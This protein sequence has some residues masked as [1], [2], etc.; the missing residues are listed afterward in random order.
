MYFYENKK[1]TTGI[2]C[3]SGSGEGIVYSHS[4]YS[5][6]PFQIAT[7][8]TMLCLF[9]TAILSDLGSSS[10]RDYTKIKT[11]IN[12]VQILVAAKGFG[13]LTKGL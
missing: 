4:F 3:Y 12:P 6:V 8:R 2:V 11:G 7:F 5:W 9:S 10:T 13:P 1:T